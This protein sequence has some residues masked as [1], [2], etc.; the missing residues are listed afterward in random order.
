MPR[1]SMT[2]DVLDM[3]ADRFRALGEPARLTILS[4]LLDG[5]RT[6]SEL[7]D[8]TGLGQANVSKHLQVLYRFGFV[9]RRKDGLYVHYKAADDGVAQLCDIMCGRIAESVDAQRSVL[10]AAATDAA[11]YAATDAASDSA[12]DSAKNAGASRAKE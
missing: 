6:V 7:V 9:S 11:T 5:E 8:V 3:I 2:P 10:E 1:F 4:A 12:S